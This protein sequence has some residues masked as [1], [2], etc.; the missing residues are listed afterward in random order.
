MENVGNSDPTATRIPFELGNL[1]SGLGLVVIDEEG[2][3]DR[4]VVTFARN[5]L[6]VRPAAVVSPLLPSTVGGFPSECLPRVDTPELSDSW[7]D[8]GVEYPSSS[9]LPAILFNSDCPTTELS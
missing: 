7:G 2:R 9:L 5:P 3:P 6:I 4:R 8:I 1:C